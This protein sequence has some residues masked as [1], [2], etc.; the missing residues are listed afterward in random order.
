MT[1]S[2]KRSNAGS[3]DTELESRQLTLDDWV[4]MLDED[5]E[6]LQPESRAP[7]HVPERS[8]AAASEAQLASAGVAL[9]TTR[10]VADALHVH[11]RTVQRLVERGELAVV[12]LGAAIRFDP[13]ELVRLIAERTRTARSPEPEPDALRARPAGVSF[14]KRLRSQ[15]A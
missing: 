2:P 7:H 5:A 12:R 11:P 13:A 4:H 10:E 6:T 14:A 3:P 1:D 8:A 15:P 9:L